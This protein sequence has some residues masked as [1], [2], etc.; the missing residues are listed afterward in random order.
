[1]SQVL[2]YADNPP[3]VPIVDPVHVRRAWWGVVGLF[4]IHGLTVSTWVSRIPSV[5]A[6]LHLG[7][8]VFGVSLFGFAVGSMI[9]IPLS[10]WYTT[11]YGSRR[12]SIVTCIGLCLVVV[13]PAFAINAPTLFAALF[14]FGAILGA[15]DVAMNS[16][17]V[18]VERLLGSPT[19]S[20]FHA[21]YSL[22]GIA[23]ATAG[24]WI[25]SRAVPVKEHFL[26]TGALFVAFAIAIA[27]LVIDARSE[28]GVPKSRVRLRQMPLALVALCVIG[29]CIFL[30]EGA[31][32]DWTAV[33]LRQVLYSG[34]GMAAAGFAVFSAAMAVFR[35]AGD[36]ITVWLGAAWT[37]R[38]GALVAAFGLAWALLVH[39]PYWALP[40][41]AMVGAGF[42]SIIPLVF[43]AGG[44]IP[45]V[46][47]GAGVATVSGIGYLGFLV[48]PTAI[49]F[50]SEFTSLRIGLGFV[51]MLSLL[52]AS[53]VNAAADVFGGKPT[54][55]S[56]QPPHTG[57]SPEE[58]IQ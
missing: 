10:G 20:R 21:M 37:I 40:G 28:T 47:E 55:S 38:A 13:L 4:L 32:A 53:L 34:P 36:A 43:A 8:G 26:G 46:S 49:G 16:Q 56:G 22:G 35:L 14:A 27:P 51:V 7:D 1:M 48:G 6:G 15:N 58:K 19:M 42:S 44:R 18:S 30:S 2:E 11:R 9:G 17:A 39:D 52:A 41:F 31:M 3:A 23:G 24:G 45:H 25:A 5:K 50:I 57:R 12:T 54:A 33:Y 29:F